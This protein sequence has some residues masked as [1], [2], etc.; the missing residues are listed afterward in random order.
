VVGDG[1]DGT[2]AGRPLVDGS[3]R[4]E[5]RGVT[6]DRGD[7][8]ADTGLDLPVPVHVGIV[9]HD[10]APPADPAARIGLALAEDVHH[11]A[12]QVARMR[13]VGQVQAS[14]TDRRPDTVSVEGVPHHAVPDAVAATDA[15]DVAEQDDLGPV[16]FHP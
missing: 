12:P 16:E 10:V 3:D 11:A 4:D 1:D 2:A 13:P 7:H 14:V 9:E 15:G 6:R 8:A 5:D